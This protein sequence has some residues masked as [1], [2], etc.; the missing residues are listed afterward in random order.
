LRVLL[1]EDDKRL[2]QLIQQV[3]EEEHFGV[4]IAQD[5]DSGVEL[6]LRGIHDVAI[7]D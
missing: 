6:A 7:I 1:I 4:D 2:S 5:G 3:F